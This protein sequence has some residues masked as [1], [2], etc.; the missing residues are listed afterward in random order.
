MAQQHRIIAITGG[1]GAGKSV[2]SSILRV[3]GY[4]V[5]DCDS[6]AKQLM[7]TSVAIKQSLTENFG[8]DIYNGD[9]LNKS[10][11]SDIIFNDYNALQ[12]VNS[13]VHPAV[14]HDIAQWEQEHHG[15]TPL[16]VETAILKE[17][18]LDEIV[19]EVW[20]VTAPIEIRIERV[21]KRNATSRSKV[22]ER[23]NSQQ[24]I[25]DAIM[26]PVFTVINDNITPLLPQVM[27]EL[28]RLKE[29]GI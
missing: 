26:K 4:H 16:F 25:T 12:L 13:I 23:I 21:V 24:E 6:R 10:R 19:D 5:Y 14:R 11:L 15:Q 3:A 1:I 27:K 7:N 22:I 20:N 29:Q 8:Q 18:G 9:N 17:G 2:V 28:Q